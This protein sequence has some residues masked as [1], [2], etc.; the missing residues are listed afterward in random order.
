MTWQQAIKARP[1]AWTRSARGWARHLPSPARAALRALVSA[2]P[3]SRLTRPGLALDLLIAA[4]A[5]FAVAVTVGKTGNC[6][7]YGPVTQCMT[8]SSGHHLADALVA[9]F[10]TVPLALRRIRP[11][12]AFW[13]IAMAAVAAPHLAYNIVT[14]AAAGVAAYS[15]VVYSR[16]R[17]AAIVCVPLAGLLVATAFPT[18]AAPLRLPGAVAI[19]LGLMT[20]VYVAQAVR[21]W[22]RRLGESQAR[23]DRLQAEHEAATA[24]ALATERARIA[25]E[26]HDVVTHNVS[27]MIVQAGAARQVLTNSP[28]AARDALLAVESSGRAAMAELRYLLGLLS[29]AA[30]AGDLAREGGPDTDQLQPQPGLRQLGALV[31]RVRA[32]G[33]EVEL[34]AA[35]PSDLPPGLD[36]AA[37]RVIQ[38]ALTNVL[39]H[40][41]TTKATV[42]ADCQRDRLAVCVTDA[43]PRESAPVPGTPVPGTTVPGTT[44][45]G[46]AFRA[47]VAVPGTG[48][49]L[50][51]L[52]ER[53][54]VYGGELTAGP[55]PGGGWRVQTSL[56]LDAVP[57]R[58]DAELMNLAAQYRE[59]GGAEPAGSRPA[60]APCP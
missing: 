15:A 4:L 25:S 27:V 5:T 53:V 44:V 50:L 42:S 9:A 1:A 12:T 55:V 33:L 17:A 49:G 3:R 10:T 41:G 58:L 29:P 56:P 34:R 20:V 8:Q 14:M 48:R 30:D 57:A 59:Q 54:A 40:A 46:T 19:L 18:V 23:L 37:Y 51:G 32:A 22:R 26:L 47:H 52:R 60:P 21:T 28:G 39:K 35:V 45:P 24:L 31:D 38:E 2:E 43:G 13:V 7:Q 16:Y 6:A 36:L 11:L